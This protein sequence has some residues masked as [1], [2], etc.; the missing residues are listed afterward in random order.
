MDEEIKKERLK[1]QSDIQELKNEIKRIRTDMLT[2]ADG[3]RDAIH[4]YYLKSLEESRAYAERHVAHVV[5][6]HFEK[7]SHLQFCWRA[8][9]D[10]FTARINI[11]ITKRK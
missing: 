4:E 11:T 8:L 1:R 6:T 7:P 10:I 2:Q 9:K 5:Q 3:I